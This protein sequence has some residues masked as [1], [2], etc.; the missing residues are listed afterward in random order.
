MSY[1]KNAATPKAVTVGSVVLIADGT[2][3][4]SECSVRVSLDGGAWG[5]GGGTLAYDVTSGVVTYAPI[6]AE[7]NG[8]VLKIAVYKASCLGCSTTVLMDLQTIPT[9]TTLTN[10]PGDSTGVTEILTRLPDIVPGAAG[11]LF[12]AGTNAA[13]TVNITGNITGAVSTVGNVLALAAESIT[14]SVLKA[15]AGT[16]IGTAVWATATR[17][18]TAAQTFNITGNLS[19]SVGSVAAGGIAAASFAAGAINAAAI[20]DG[21]IDNATL[22]ANLEA[23]LAELDAA[24]IPADIDLLVPAGARNLTVEDH[25]EVVIT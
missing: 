18:L 9:V 12:I 11:G 24:N 13:T 10:A 4:T 6:Q 25:A 8:D 1:P 3:Q 5:A 14:A 19:G 16:E 7:T 22:A 15:D 2:V 20:A 23:R 21:A 17:Q